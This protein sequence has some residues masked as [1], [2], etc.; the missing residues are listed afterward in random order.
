MKKLLLIATVLFLYGCPGENDCDDLGRIS[1][2]DNLIKW[3][4]VQSQYN[5]GDVITVS[6]EVPGMNEYFGNTINIFDRTNDNTGLL[7]LTTGDFQTGNQLNF[8]KGFQDEG[9]RNW[10]YLPYNAEAR[11]Y[12]LQFELTLNRTGVYNLN[13]DHNIIFGEN[14]N[15]YFIDTNVEFIAGQ[16][17]QFEVIP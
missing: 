4:P 5:R 12:E 7:V 15:R 3:T 16:P 10:Y 17:F 8:I 2:V 1:R 6:L 14:C 13:N 11:N 9:V